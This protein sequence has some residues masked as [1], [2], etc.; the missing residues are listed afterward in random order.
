MVSPQVDGVIAAF[1]S[2]TC[3]VDLKQLQ[4]F[5]LSEFDGCYGQ[6]KYAAA[7]S[8][9]GEL[10]EGQQVPRCTYRHSL[11]MEESKAASTFLPN[12]RKDRGGDQEVFPKKRQFSRFSSL[13]S[14]RIMS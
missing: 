9:S 11:Y 2:V 7:Q 6:N 8:D 4:E 12:R 5:D 13:L 14:T 3:D 10:T 1:I